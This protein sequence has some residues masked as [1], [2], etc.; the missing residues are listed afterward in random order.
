MGDRGVD[1]VVALLK[2]KRDELVAQV[3]Q[4]D[5]AIAALGVSS[6]TRRYTYY[7]EGGIK[8]L[9]VNALRKNGPQSSGSLVTLLRVEHPYLGRSTVSSMLFTMREAGHVVNKQ[10]VWELS[11]TPQAPKE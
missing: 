1:D 9:I 2:S 7:G 3:G 11:D 6:T 4:I 10:G 8:A 5:Q